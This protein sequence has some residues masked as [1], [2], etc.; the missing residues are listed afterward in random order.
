M[1]QPRYVVVEGVAWAMS[2]IKGIYN[3]NNFVGI[4]EMVLRYCVSK[5]G[6]V[7][8]KGYSTMWSSFPLIE[9]LSYDDP[10]MFLVNMPIE[11]LYGVRSQKEI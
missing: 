10:Q 3:Q 8:G 4:C 2:L 1:K 11:T 6:E 9:Q 5:K 7:G